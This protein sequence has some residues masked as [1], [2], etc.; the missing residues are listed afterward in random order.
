MRVVKRRGIDKRRKKSGENWREEEKS[1]RRKEY[2]IN[3]PYLHLI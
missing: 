3:T 1:R 2:G